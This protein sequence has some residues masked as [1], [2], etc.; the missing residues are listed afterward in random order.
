M[1]ILFNELAFYLPL[2]KLSSDLESHKEMFINIII[3][4]HH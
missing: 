1:L 2:K 3:F 4:E